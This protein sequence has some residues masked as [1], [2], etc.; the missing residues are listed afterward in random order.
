[1]VTFRDNIQG[2]LAALGLLVTDEDTSAGLRSARTGR[3]VQSFRLFGFRMGFQIGAGPV[4]GMDLPGGLH[5]FPGWTS[6]WTSMPETV[7]NS[8]RVLA[9]TDVRQSVQDEH[10]NI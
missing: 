7:E 1:M 9:G 10:N 8:L 3:N 6:F 2:E 4:K 5:V